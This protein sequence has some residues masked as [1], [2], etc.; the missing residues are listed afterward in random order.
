LS[1]NCSVRKV[2]VTGAAGFVGR[3]IVKRLLDAGDEVHA[4]DCVAEYTGGIDPGKGWP[5]FDPRDCPRFRFYKEDCRTWFGRVKDTDFDYAF[6]LAAM[7]GGRLMIENNPLAVADDL[8]IDAAYWGWAKETRPKKTACFSSSAAY[9]IRLQRADYHVLLKEEMISFE[10]DIGM[11][12][13]SY[14]W[15]KLT[16]EYLAQLA[17]EKHGLKS[18]CY[19]PF[20]GYGEDQDDAYPFPSIVKRVLAHRGAPVVTVWGTGTQMRDF[21]HI[22]DCMDGI[23]TTID[24]IDDGGA[25][26][27]STGI[28]TSFINFAKLAAGV[29]GYHPEVKGLSDKPAGVHARGG[30]TTKQRQLGFQYKIDFR[31][32][33]E[34]AIE[35]FSAR[36]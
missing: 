10:G 21:I 9:P 16:C 3:H 35:Y 25:V 11:P 36:R 33:I 2:L 23:L 29:V 19:R 8:S 13:M 20:S 12:D 5:L 4:V 14:G 26:N 31:T 30:D 18:I 34:R 24:R 7:V 28:L 27:L 22:E 6:H 1:Y 17:Y 32:G 15:A